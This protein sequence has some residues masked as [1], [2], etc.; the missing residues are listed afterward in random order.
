MRLAVIDSPMTAKFLTPEERAFIIYQQSAY[1][2]HS[3]WVIFR[4]KR[5]WKRNSWRGG[6]LGGTTFLGRSHWLAGMSLITEWHNH[7]IHHWG[8]DLD[9]QFYVNERLHAEWVLNIV[10]Y[11]SIFHYL[12]YMASRFSFRMYSPSKVS[13]AWHPCTNGAEQSFTSKPFEY[14]IAI[15]W[16]LV[17]R[18]SGLVTPFQ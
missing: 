11:L 18:N 4:G 2:K 12:Q 17:A 13:I 5:T 3:R 16:I 1:L 6:T 9:A 10:G 7:I 14:F 15:S 8:L